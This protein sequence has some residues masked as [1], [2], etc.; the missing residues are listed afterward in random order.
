MS[1]AP[2]RAWAALADAAA[3][4]RRHIL[5]GSLAVGLA[6]APT[7]PGAALLAAAGVLAALAA[8]RAPGLALAAAA[9]LLAGA[10]AGDARL[11]TIDSG[12]E[13]VRPGQG[14][15]AAAHLLERPRPAP[16]GISFTAR[17][18]TGPARGA[19]VLVRVPRHDARTTGALLARAAPGEEVRLAGVLRR[20]PP[21]TG[22][23]GYLRRRGL[24]GELTAAHVRATGR[25]RG[26]AA[27]VARH[28]APAGRARRGGGPERGR[29]GPCPR[30]GARP[31]RG[32]RAGR[33]RRL[34][35]R[36]PRSPARGQWPERDAA[37]GAGAPPAG[38]S[39]PGPV[40][41]FR[42][43]YRSHRALRA[44]RGR[45]AVA[46]ARGGHGRGVAR[47]ARSG[48]ALLPRRTRCCWPRR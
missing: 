21:G 27:G 20:P 1:P 44:G 38:R 33:A 22:Y 14:V 30:H 29:G 43:H 13:R 3:G 31:G 25:R 15:A 41:P 23:A 40:G 39:G 24:A 7:S 8:L 26:G 18:T 5:I 48:P 34:Q 28:A 2:A 19:R 11:A 4:A 37:R 17:L 36:G 12:R 46:P 32:H 47:G 6:L 16:F 45:G 35:G 10:W 9:L 42:G